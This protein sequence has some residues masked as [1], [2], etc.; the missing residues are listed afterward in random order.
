MNH[1]H[2]KVLEAIFAHP[3]SANI[4]FK[5]VVHVLEALGAEITNKSG[6][7]IGISFKGHEIALANSH[8]AL[9]KDDVIRVKKFLIDRGVD[10]AIVAQSV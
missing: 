7:R 9:S 1:K 10:P 2:L 3:T 4:D 8:H 5:E 6:N